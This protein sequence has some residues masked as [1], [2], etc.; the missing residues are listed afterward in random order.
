MENTPHDNPWDES[1]RPQDIDR[2]FAKQISACMQPIFDE[3]FLEGIPRSCVPHFLWITAKHAYT[4]AREVQALQSLEGVSKDALND[5]KNAWNQRAQ[6]IVLIYESY[7]ALLN[8]LT[9]PYNATHTFWHH[10]TPR[11]AHENDVDDM[12]G[13]VVDQTTRS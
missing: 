9:V 2:L 13:A 4:T 8:D 11:R 6:I 7:C 3:R 1:T 10:Y 12:F 5:Y